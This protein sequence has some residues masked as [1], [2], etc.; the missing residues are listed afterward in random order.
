[1]FFFGLIIFEKVVRLLLKPPCELYLSIE[2][3]IAP[4]YNPTNPPRPQNRFFLYRKNYNKFLGDGNNVPDVSKGAG[5]A[6]NIE[7]HEVRMY[8]EILESLA[9]EMHK[10]LYPGYKYTSSGDQPLSC[11]AKEPGLQ[12][13]QNNIGH[14]TQSPSP[15]VSSYTN[16]DTNLSPFTYS[17]LYNINYKNSI[18][19]TYTDDDTNPSSF[20]Y[21]NLSTLHSDKNALELS[22]SYT[23]DI[24]NP[25]SFSNSLTS[26]LPRFTPP[27]S[28]INY[29]NSPS[30]YTNDNTNRSSS[31]SLSPPHS[32]IN[33]NNS[34]YLSSSYT[35]NNT[36]ISPSACFNLSTTYSDIKNSLDPSSFYT[37]GS[38]NSSSSS[39]TFFSPCPTPIINY[40]N[41][42]CAQNNTIFD[43]INELTRPNA[44]VGNAT[45]E[46]Q[47]NLL[48]R[49][50]DHSRMN[51]V[52]IS[53]DNIMQ[54]LSEFQEVQEVLEDKT[55]ENANSSYINYNDNS[56]P[57]SQSQNQR[58]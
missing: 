17:N 50:F 28:N 58:Q 23:S 25:S 3:L 52:I 33:N 32:N 6:W 21:S 49:D 20:T 47:T 1:M 18:H 43:N 10:L 24:T 53:Y 48:G 51:N 29:N 7:S 41:P 44:I 4:R 11:E 22:S 15:H 31:T 30:S 9:L 2:E 38:T 16:G 57:Q 55:Q 26:L 34:P 12:Q 54:K 46:S 45:P 37:N 5:K 40:G 39:S 35:N 42:S 56:N 13:K 19:L 14:V 36:N 8:F 27:H